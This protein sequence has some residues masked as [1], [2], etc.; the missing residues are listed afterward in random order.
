MVEGGFEDLG[1]HF[2]KLWFSH[3]FVEEGENV[4]AEVVE[5]VNLEVAG[6][7]EDFSNSLSEVAGIC[8]LEVCIFHI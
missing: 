1:G 3:M 7:G 4:V 6:I 2:E 5:L 8:F